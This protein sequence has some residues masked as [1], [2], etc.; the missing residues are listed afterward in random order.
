MSTG[1]F[2]TI[3]L[4][5]EKTVPFF[6]SVFY[7]KGKQV[8]LR[9][10]VLFCCLNRAPTHHTAAIWNLHLFRFLYNIVLRRSEQPYLSVCPCNIRQPIAIPCVV[11]VSTFDGE[12]AR[13]VRK[14]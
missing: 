11:Y 6:C 5:I 13:K 3:V 8:I 14:E 7:G 2:G 1:C 10:I 9:Y 4:P 12:E